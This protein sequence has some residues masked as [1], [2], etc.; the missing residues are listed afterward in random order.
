[1][2]LILKKDIDTLGYKDELVTVKA[3]YGRNY[4][5]PQGLATL[6]TSSVK[7]MHTETLKQRAHKEVKLK[8]EATKM[9]ESLKSMSVKVGAKVGENGKIFGSVNSLQV[10][11]AIQKLGYTVERK[12]I[13]IKEEPIKHI[14]K[15]EA[16][17]KFHKEVTGTITFEVVGE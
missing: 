10:A 17:V 7:K 14:G 12:N 2:E 15:Y 4:L 6:A 1:M 5:I 3:G 16:E 13:L 11:D 9:A 8:A